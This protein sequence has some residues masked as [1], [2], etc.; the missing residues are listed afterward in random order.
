MQI[1]FTEAATATAALL[2][3]QTLSA[4]EPDSG[5][6]LEESAE[7]DSMVIT[8]DPLGTRADELPTPVNI[9]TGE[10]LYLRNNGGSIGEVLEGELGVTGTYFGPVASR[11]VI[12][13]QQGPRVTVLE[14]RIGTLD[15]SDISPDHAVSVDPLIAEQIEVIRGTGTL[16]YG[17]GAEGGVVNV[18]THRIPKRL[19]E[20][21]LT[22]AF[23]VRGDTAAQEEAVAA[24]VDGAFG[25]FAWHLDGVS[26]QSDD[27]DIDGY[28]T[29]T[30]IRN[31]EAAEGEPV[32]EKKGTLANSDSDTDS[33]AAG[34]SWIGDLF[35]LGA[36]YSRYESKYGLPG[37]G[38]H[39]DEDE[40]DSG[41]DDGGA[42]IKLDQDRVDLY[43]EYTGFRGPLQTLRM[44]AGINDYQHTEFEPGG[45]PGTR[46]KNDAWEGRVE[47]VHALGDWQG[48]GGMQYLSRDFE[49]IGDEAFVPKTDT[50]SL[51]LFLLE[52]KDYDDLRFSVS[53]RYET[54]EHDP[55]GLSSD[56]DEDALSFATGFVWDGGQALVPSLSL[57]YTERHPKTEE[58][59]SDGPHLATGLFEV[60]DASLGKE[61]NKSVDLGLKFQGQRLRWG[62]AVFYKAAGDYIYLR[63][64]GEEEDD[65]P[66]AQYVQ[67]DA[68][69]Y[70]YEAEVETHIAR[71]SRGDL[72][73][74]LWSDYVRGKLDQNREGTDDLPRVPPQRFGAELSWLANRWS[75][76]VEW[77]RYMK[78]SKVSE[79][80]LETG[81]YT[82]VDANLLLGFDFGPGHLDFFL[83]GTNLLDE[84]GRRHTS[85]LKDY[86]PLP[87]RSLHAGLRFHFF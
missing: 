51:G 16:I 15:V 60:G 10:R 71:T 4:Q 36:S 41:P 67:D 77:T 57:S 78:Q 46:F 7:L 62:A 33:W 27:V 21:G 25:R 86:A 74:R 9:M 47:L 83:R 30:S 3:F 17:S 40:P 54:M 2:L 59:Y 24:K 14:N 39:A 61:K 68:V 64:T 75:S 29:R 1:R 82:M 85:F 70:G 56:Y 84:R 65:L 58:L 49:A 43:A 45:E 72:D 32:D 48:V 13:G 38:E 66:V 22:G 35:T 8:A 12:R 79:F 6:L 55:D 80:E 63:G 44:E 31:S 26:R 20:S 87:G 73:L 69:F 19:P 34:G 42:S 81:A 18:V 53:T 11:P 5:D 76:S 28:A 52:E 50:R 37:P 23:E